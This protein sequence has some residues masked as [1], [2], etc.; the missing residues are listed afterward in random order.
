MQEIN[1]QQEQDHVWIKSIFGVLEEYHSLEKY[2]GFRK[3]E[4]VWM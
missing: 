1:N 3:Q 2:F 4:G